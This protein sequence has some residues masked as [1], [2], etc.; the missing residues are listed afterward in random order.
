M[1]KIDGAGHV[2][3]NFVAEDPAI[4]RPATEFT[5]DWF[6]AIQGEL[7]NVILPKLGLDKNNNSQL[8][9]A[10]NMMIA[11][12]VNGGDYKQSVRVATTA[13][14]NLAAPGASI[15]T[16]VM[17]L[18]DRFLDKDNA[19]LALRGIYI[20]NGAAVPATRAG[21]ADTGAEFNGGAIIPV[22]S[23]AVNADTNWQI[24]NDGTVTIGTTGLTFQPI[25]NISA[26]SETVAGKAKIATQALTDAGTDDLT[27]ITPLKLKNTTDKGIGY[28]QSWADVTASRAL[29]TTYTNS[30]GK[31]IEISVWGTTGAASGGLNLYV[32]S[33]LI[34]KNFYNG[35]G[36]NG[37]QIGAI[38]PN[39][40][41]Y[42][43]TIN[44]TAVTLNGWFELR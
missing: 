21:D 26:A 22:E 10:I 37:P 3:N 6:N 42:S 16:T 11:D 25:S 14:I 35:A 31:P 7:V 19:T 39:G 15:D 24:T 44:S 4:N 33:V 12:A 1:H 20:W 41:T 17:V 30:S 36:G 28:G 27:F 9:T 38:I 43:V 5:A 8:L 23:G 18:G 40:A 13:A 32:N 34:S 2:D 29:A